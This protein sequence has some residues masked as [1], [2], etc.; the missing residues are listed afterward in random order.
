MSARETLLLVGAG[1][2]AKS[3]I[4]VIEQAGAFVIGGLI[5]L[6]EQVGSTVLGYPVLG[7]DEDLPGL[8]Q[9]YPNAIVTVGQI[10]S[11]KIRERLFHTLLENGFHT[12]VVVSPHA[13]VSRHAT[14]GAGTVVL[15]G[16][17][18]NAGASVGRNCILNS[19]CLVEHDASVGDH[20]HI[21]TGA[22]L[23]GDVRVGAGCFI[24]SGSVTRESVTIG[25][26]CVIGMGQKVLK[27]C[28]DRTRL[29]A[30]GSM[31]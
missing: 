22:I 19:R 9:H 20:S 24:G 30:P 21:A 1:G 10:L 11:P 15:H 8:R 25:C 6:P 16:A 28:P 17:V 2:H 14:V 31:Q 29:P 13:I 4:D 12:P 23:N 5:G 27:D 26:E 18:V 7:I 3:C